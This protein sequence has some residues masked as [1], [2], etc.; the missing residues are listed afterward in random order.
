MNT[1]SCP[2]CRLPPKLPPPTLDQKNSPPLDLDTADLSLPIMWLGQ[3]ARLLDGSVSLHFLPKETQ[4]RLVVAAPHTVPVA[5][6]SPLLVY[7]V[8]DEPALQHMYRAW[9][10]APFDP[11]SIVVPGTL[12]FK[13]KH[14]KLQTRVNL[15]SIV[16][17][18][19]SLPPMEA[20]DAMRDFVPLVVSASPRPDAI[21]VDQNLCSQVCRSVGL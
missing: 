2:S 8:D 20:D 14:L 6:S 15:R 13:L 19:S 17:A 9:L 16:V 11:M 4:L 5:L 3:V 21:I 10:T 18:D 1:A 12:S 7:F